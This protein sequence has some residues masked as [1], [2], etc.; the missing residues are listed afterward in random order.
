MNIKRIADIINN[1]F[2][3]TI[4]TCM[5][6]GVEK[7]G[8]AIK[9]GNV[10]PVFYPENYIGNERE[11]AMSIIEDM[12][13]L[14]MPKFDDEVFNNWDKAKELIRI[15]LRPRTS[16]DDAVTFPYLDL[17]RYLYLDLDE[18]KTA[19]V[20]QDFLDKLGVDKYDA[21]EAAYDNTEK[22]IKISSMREI[23]KEIGIDVPEDA[24]D[25]V[26]IT[27]TERYRGASGM[28][29]VSVLDS[30][31]EK[32]NCKKIAILPS[33]IHEIIA[34]EDKG[35]EKYGDYNKMV[36]SINKT[37]VSPEERLANHIYVYDTITENT[38]LA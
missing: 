20:S 19:K 10:S 25:Q 37:Q 23:M 31:C 30:V 21:L 13:N 33:S 3:A 14:E 35:S 7:K 36:R 2:P 1:T 24:E 15:G 29:F 12:K 16:A 9:N 11:I 22:E 34:V 4:V 6:G 8:I 17:E 32:L 28:L 26:I 38:A 18:S 27:N 5:K